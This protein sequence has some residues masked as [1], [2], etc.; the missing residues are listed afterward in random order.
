LQI[1]KECWHSIIRPLLKATAMTPDELA[2]RLLN[3]AARCGKVVDALP[4]TRLGR[5]VAGQLVRS[6]TAPAPNYEEGCAAESRADFIHKLSIVLKELRESRCWI[7]LISRAELLPEAR[8]A[9]LLDEATQ[10]CN[11]IGQ[12]VAT[13]KGK[14]DD[15]P[16]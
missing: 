5:H 10:L 12:S 16:E 8:M 2:D 4:D 14:G 6:G 11:I 1:E 15:R 13:A 3:F 9:G 7:R